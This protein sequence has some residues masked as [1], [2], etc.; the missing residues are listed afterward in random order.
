M[1]KIY[2]FGDGFA[3]GH[4]WPEWPQILQALLPDYEIIN[5]AGIGAGPEWLVH[6]FISHIPDMQNSTVIFQWPQPDRFDKLIEDAEWQ[7]IANSDSVYDFNQYVVN[8][9]KWWLSSASAESQVQEYH[10]KFI[11]SKQHQIRSDNYKILVKNTLENIGCSYVYTTTKDQDEFSKTVENIK[12]RQNEIQPSPVVHF[13]WLLAAILPR[14]SIE[15][16]YTRANTLE[17]LINEKQWE[18]YYFDREQKWISLLE[19][20]NNQ[21]V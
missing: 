16:D 7:Q 21:T 4:I 1:N 18:P 20:L 3:A 8:D 15:F 6:R 12:H 19:D 17:K 2:T 11:Q 5:T 13:K 10:N 9:E 14:I